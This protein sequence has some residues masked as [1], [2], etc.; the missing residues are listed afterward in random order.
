ML[1]LQLEAHK[2]CWSGKQNFLGVHFTAKDGFI[3]P[4]RVLWFVLRECAEN[5]L[6]CWWK[7]EPTHC[8]F[9]TF[10]IRHENWKLLLGAFTN[11]PWRSVRRSIEKFLN[12]IC[13]GHTWVSARLQMKRSQPEKRPTLYKNQNPMSK[14]LIFLYNKISVFIYKNN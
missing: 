7:F 5:A 1:R 14:W 12:L 11:G 10:S 9:C 6:V 4:A 3:A 13:C 8:Q 2:S